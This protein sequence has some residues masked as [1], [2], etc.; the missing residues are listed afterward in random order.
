MTTNLPSLYTPQL[1]DGITEADLPKDPLLQDEYEAILGVFARKHLRD[2]FLLS[3]L[4]RATGL[5]LMEVMR[6][7]PAHVRRHPNATR[8]L[9]YRG[10]KR[11]K[12]PVTREWTKIEDWEEVEIKH[13]IAMDLDAYIR[14]EGAPDHWRVFRKTARAYQLAFREAAVEVTGVRHHPHELRGLYAVDI[15]GQYK[16]A[17]DLQTGLLLAAKM[18]GHKDVRTTM[19][20]YV[21]VHSA[22]K[23]AVNQRVRA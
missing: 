4:L 19:A 6:V 12:D 7:T 8:L 17:G 10:K 15:V 16:D 21:R 11:R 1:P 2:W 5:R 20:Y 13:E 3:R 18:L 9:V 23:S 22:A 14:I